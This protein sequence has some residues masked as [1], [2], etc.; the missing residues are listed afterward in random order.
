MDLAAA[1]ATVTVNLG[2]ALI[3]LGEWRLGL[4]CVF[5]SLAFRMVADEAVWASP[6]IALLSPLRAEPLVWGL[7]AFSLAVFASSITHLTLR[8]RLVLG[9]VCFT[10][11]YAALYLFFSPP[12]VLPLDYV[13]LF[14]AR[15]PV[16]TRPVHVVPGALRLGQW[17]VSS[18]PFLAVVA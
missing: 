10:A 5:A 17:L 9:A 15:I 7:A 1:G 3:M 13:G 14:V 12:A 6:S 8:K 11:Y 18:T 16:V 4:V 2:V